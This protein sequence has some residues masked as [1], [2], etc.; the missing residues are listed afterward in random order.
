MVN[1]RS[2]SN[3][4]TR[5]KQNVNLQTVMINGQRLRLATRTVRTLK[6]MTEQM[7]GVRPSKMQKKAAR[8]A[9]MAKAAKA[10]K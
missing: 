10:A 5:R 7:T 9:E 1:S 3:I 8:K 4:A 2:H 6:K